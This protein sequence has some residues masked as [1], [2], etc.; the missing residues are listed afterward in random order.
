MLVVGRSCHEPRGELPIESYPALGTANLMIEAN[1]SI[2]VS[3][4]RNCELPITPLIVEES[5]S[6]ELSDKMLVDGAGTG[7]AGARADALTFDHSNTT[8]GS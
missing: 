3:S 7:L 5:N 8:I 4:V 6:P 2:P 1:A